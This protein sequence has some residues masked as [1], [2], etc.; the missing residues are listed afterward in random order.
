MQPSHAISDLF[1]APKRLGMKRLAGAYAWQDLIN[2]GAII[3]GGSDAPVERGD[4]MIEFYAAVARK[5]IDGFSSEGWHTEQA[6]SREQALRMFTIWPAVAAFKEPE[7]GSI[8]AGKLADVTILSA[9][10]M[11]IPQAQIPQTRCLM[12]VIGGEIVFDSTGNTV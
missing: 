8:E 10:I 3:A 7:R 9:D 11:K 6:V 12:T 1:F 4:P 5:S 2:S